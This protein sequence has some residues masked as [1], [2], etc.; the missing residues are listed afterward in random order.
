MRTKIKQN[1]ESRERERERGIFVGVESSIKI[2]Q[3]LGLYGLHIFQKIYN[4][5]FFLFSQNGPEC[6]TILHFCCI[7]NGI[8]VN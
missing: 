1:R 5:S 8:K 2:K 7:T 3:I 6:C 4:D